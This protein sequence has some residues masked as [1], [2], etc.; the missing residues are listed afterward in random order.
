[1]EK[2]SQEYLI[3]LS[4]TCA[5]E[6]EELL[7]KKYDN[8]FDELKNSQSKE[9]IKEFKETAKQHID[10]IKDKMLKFDFEG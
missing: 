4:F 10:L 9:S 3:R 5:I 7:Q 8:Y 6:R 2:L 1:M